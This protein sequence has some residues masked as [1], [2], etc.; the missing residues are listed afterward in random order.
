L[1]SVG[2]LELSANNNR[3]DY[4][5]KCHSDGSKQDLSFTEDGKKFIPHIFEV[6]IGVDRSLYAVLE[7]SFVKEKERNVLKLNPR[8]SPYDC[9]VFPLVNKDG[10]DIKAKEIVKILR[11][12][13]YEVF[14][15]DSG[16]VGR[17]YRRMDEIGVFICI[18]VDGESLKDNQKN[19]VCTVVLSHHFLLANPIHL[20]KRHQLFL[21]L[22]AV[23]RLLLLLKYYRLNCYSAQC[24]AGG[25]QMGQV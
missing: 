17:R 19:L 11:D 1:T 2:W 18:T 6:S 7:L 21:H 13:L 9:A 3:Q 12:N 5:L 20:P 25:Q 14:Y 15:D 22:Q 10:M 8:L 23:K 24:H 4:D 16:S